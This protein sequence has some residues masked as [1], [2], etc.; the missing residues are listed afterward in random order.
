V[1]LHELQQKCVHVTTHY[2]FACMRAGVF[3]RA[4]LS[5][6]LL[7]T[8]TCWNRSY[9]GL[10]TWHLVCRCLKVEPSLCSAIVGMQSTVVTSHI[11]RS[12][13]C[14]TD[15]LLQRR[16]DWARP[17]RN[18]QAL[19]APLARVQSCFCCITGCGNVHYCFTDY[20]SCLEEQ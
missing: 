14:Q 3:I 16:T 4:L 13:S 9:V 8:C 6:P 20:Y 11:L 17:W 15:H 10:L 1:H 2:T 12:H 5:F 18:F 7:C 19:S